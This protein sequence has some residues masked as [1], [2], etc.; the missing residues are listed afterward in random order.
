MPIR[1]VEAEAATVIWLE[2]VQKVEVIHR[3]FVL[4]CVHCRVR[5]HVVHE[6]D[7]EAWSAG[8]HRALFDLESLAHSDSSRRAG[9]PALRRGISPK[10]P[11]KQLSPGARNRS[12]TP[13]KFHSPSPL[14]SPRIQ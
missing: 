14:R 7:H 1:N 11:I 13:R 2:D 9:S 10:R 12:S 5:L 4:T 6:E 3:G 8:L